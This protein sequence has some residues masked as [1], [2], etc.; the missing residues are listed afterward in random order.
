[1]ST[2]LLSGFEPFGGCSH[3]PSA[4][5]AQAQ[6]GTYIEG[7]RI[8]GAVLPVVRYESWS[9]LS[10]II[11]QHQPMAV[12]ALGQSNRAGIHLER[13]AYN[14]DH[15]RISDNKGNQ[16]QNEEIIMGAPESHSSTLPLQA[17]YDDLSQQ[18]IDVHFSTDAGRFV[19]NHLFF[20]LQH[21]LQ[22]QCIPSGFVHLPFEYSPLV[23][24]AIEVLL[25]TVV[26]EH[27]GAT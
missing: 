9:Y 14:L 20:Q 17:M 22:A 26:R 11:D 23:E 19:C 3:N 24:K 25:R 13:M 10:A 18:N 4:R 6:H 2:I 27:Y 16:P 7:V 5:I 12:I 1:M 15:Y 21:A 8:V